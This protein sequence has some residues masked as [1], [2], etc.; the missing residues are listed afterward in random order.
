M[1]KLCICKEN[2]EI[3]YKGRLRAF[4]S[5]QP[6]KYNASKHLF[7]NGQNPTLESK[8]SVPHYND[9]PYKLNFVKALEIREYNKSDQQIFID[10]KLN[11]PK[12]LVLEC[13]TSLH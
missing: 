10:E 13:L 11:T 4:K 2:F 6:Q 3:G 5:K 1:N 7:E 9:N 8:I 12:S